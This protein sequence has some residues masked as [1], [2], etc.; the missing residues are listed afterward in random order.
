MKDYGLAPADAETLVSARELAEYFEDTGRARAAEA[1]GELGDRRGPPPHEGAEDFGGGCVVVPGRAD[2]SGGPAPKLVESGAISAA[3]AKEVFAAMLDSPAEAEAIVAE[4]GLGAMRDS[5]ALE[6]I[7]AEI[8]AGQPVAGRPLPVR[9]DADL[10]LVRRT[11]HE[12]DGRPGGSGGPA[13]G[14]DAGARDDF[15][16]TD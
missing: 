12:E 14:A 5:G 16:R 8:V 3:S 13:G 15:R 10:R 4:K 1:R 11:G 2:A 7:V 6:A 9:K